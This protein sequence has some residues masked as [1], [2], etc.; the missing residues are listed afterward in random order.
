M[1]L[2]GA[3]FIVK[4][5]LLMLRIFIIALLAAVVAGTTGTVV[6]A[7]GA[8]LK[9]H[10]EANTDSSVLY[11]LTNGAVVN[12]TCATVGTVVSGSQ[13][14]TDQ[15]DRV[16]SS[17]TNGVGYASHA[18]IAT[19]ES[20]P[21][22]DASSTGS[23]TVVVASGNTLHVHS[24]PSSSSSTLYSLDNG[25]VV[26][27]TC[28]TTGDTI[29]GSQGTTN[30][31]F[32]INSNGYA[33]AAYIAASGSPGNC[34]SAPTISTFQMAL[35]YGM[36]NIGTIYVGCAAGNYRFG[37]VAP[38]DMYHDG[39]TCGQSRVYFQPA[40]S[41]GF[42]CSG[43]MVEMFDAA[44]IYL[45]YQSSTAIKDYVPQVSK[46]IIQPGD[47]LAKYGHVVMYIGNGQVMESSPYIQ[48]SDSSWT[49]TRIN[50]DSSYM[51]S[52][53]YTAHRYPGLY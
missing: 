42:D 48:N 43:L 27:L 18:Y 11:S 16:E 50:A 34:S 10:T 15:W 37:V 36:S 12:L 31:W 49:G 30:E 20:L 53:D 22:C 44:G 45:P 1:A 13:G 38:Y 41:V 24:Q 2:Y 23:G 7:S 25:A 14:T 9:V 46:S 17:A 28:A 47:M 35:D 51:N 19:T 4:W 5:N 40:G 33:S 21:S 3:F 39:T 8:T 52:A 26:E 32:K 29:S 6:V